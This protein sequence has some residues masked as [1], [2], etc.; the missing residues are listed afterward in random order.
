[1]SSACEGPWVPQQSAAQSAVGGLWGSE[2]GG[3]GTGSAYNLCPTSCDWAAPT[4]GSECRLPPAPRL[5]MGHPFISVHSG[6]AG[7]PGQRGALSRV[8]PD[9]LPRP[10]S[11]PRYLCCFSAGMTSVATAS[12]SS[13]SGPRVPGGDTRGRGSRSQTLGA[14]T[15]LSL[16]ICRGGP[17]AGNLAGA[18][19]QAISMKCDEKNL[20]MGYFHSCPGSGAESWPCHGPTP[21]PARLSRW[22]LTPHVPSFVR[23]HSPKLEDSDNPQGLAAQTGIT[24]CRWSTG[25]WGTC[26]KVRLVLH[27]WVGR[28]PSGLHAVPENTVYKPSGQPGGSSR[29][30]L[31]A[32]EW[33]EKVGGDPALA[34]PASGSELPGAV[35]ARSGAGNTGTRPQ[36]QKQ[37]LCAGTS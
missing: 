10:G 3:S 23:N 13:L 11:G 18:K 21:C 9:R 12:P 32:A 15:V 8:S 29:H 22:P 19:T 30:R 36:T 5:L 4:P 17:A 2:L 1:M 6:D 14:S 31:E 34:R 28:G 33:P 37:V 24:S 27:S 20:V 35:P 26:E 16:Q 7:A 25:V